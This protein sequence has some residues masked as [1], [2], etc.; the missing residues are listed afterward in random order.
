MTECTGNPS[1]ANNRWEVW[2][3]TGDEDHDVV[4]VAKGICFFLPFVQFLIG[5]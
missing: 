1:L 4:K 5:W 3:R 2:R